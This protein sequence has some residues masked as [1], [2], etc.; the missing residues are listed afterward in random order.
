MWRRRVAS[1]TAWCVMGLD[2]A[3]TASCDLQLPAYS[4]PTFRGCGR[5]AYAADQW[6]HWHSSCQIHSMSIS[7]PF[8]HQARAFLPLVNHSE[9]W[10]EPFTQEVVML[11]KFTLIFYFILLFFL[12]LH[13]VC[14]FKAAVF[15]HLKALHRLYAHTPACERAHKTPGENYSR[16]HIATAA[17]NENFAKQ[18]QSGPYYISLS[19]CWKE[20]QTRLD[21]TKATRLISLLRLEMAKCSNSPLRSAP[22]AK[23]PFCWT[24]TNCINVM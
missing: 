20:M 13:V 14:G 10:S 9:P 21:N 16:R 5:D 11:H 3:V 1:H 7:H 4:N 24:Q 23:S 6:G 8:C 17:L 18:T 15:H 19:W 2:S 22:Q 12:A